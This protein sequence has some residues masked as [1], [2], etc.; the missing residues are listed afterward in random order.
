MKPTIVVPI[1]AFLS[2]LVPGVTRRDPV[3]LVDSDHHPHIAV[4]W[5]CKDKSTVKLEG[6]REYLS[7]NDKTP[8]G[9]NL[10]CYA[11]LGGMRGDYGLGSPGAVDVRVGF[12]KIDKQKPF[13]ENMADD[14]AVTVVFSSLKFSAPA[15][16]KPETV[17]QHCK[18]EDPNNVLGC[19]GDPQLLITWNTYSKTEDMGGRLNRRNGRQGVLGEGNASGAKV[20][21]E[22]DE[23]GIVSM[24]AVVPYALFKH[25]DDPWLRSNPGDFIE[26]IHFHIEFEVIAKEKA[27]EKKAT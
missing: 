21:F 12:Y 3:F 27:P 19:A 9:K 25:A 22:S 4:S 15:K 23:K 5:P 17:V 24:T 8:F 2:L 13:F 14:S 16:A 18:F 26:P 20:T 7:P 6:D 10:A 11:A 1:F